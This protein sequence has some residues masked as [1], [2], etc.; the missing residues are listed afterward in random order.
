MA[1]YERVP[2]KQKQKGPE[3]AVDMLTDILVKY[4]EIKEGKYHD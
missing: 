4:L 2:A 1:D 3:E